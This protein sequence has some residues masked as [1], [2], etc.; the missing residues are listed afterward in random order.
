LA[1]ECL[2]GEQLP[3]RLGDGSTSWEDV[4]TDL[5]VPKPGFTGWIGIARRPI[6]PSL[7][8][9]VRSWGPATDNYATGIH[10]PLTL[11]AVSFATGRGDP[12]LLVAADIGWFKN[13]ED[14]AHVR[15]GVLDAVHADPTCVL[16]NLSHTHAGP[17]GTLLDGDEPARR[18]LDAVREAAANAARDAVA[19]AAP[20]TLACTVGRCDLAANRDLTA[21][22]RV[23]VGFNPNPR[24]DDTVLVGRIA[25][26][27]GAVLAVLVNYACH[28]TTLAWQNRL[29]SPDYVG[30]AREVVETAVPGALC[31]FLQGAAGELA[32]RHQ[33]VGDTEVA[34]RHGRSLGHAVMSALEGMPP[35]GSALIYRGV[36]ES[37]AALGMWEPAAYE[38]ASELDALTIEVELPLRRMPTIEEL[39]QTWAGINPVSLDER[40]RRARRV[41]AHYVNRDPYPFRVWIWRIGDC[42]VVGIPGEPYSWLQEEL[43]ARHPGR[44]LF[45]LGVTN[46]EMSAY[47]PV[48]SAY[49]P[50]RYQSWQ[51]P[52]AR[53]CLERVLEAA[54]AAVARLAGGEARAHTTRWRRSRPTR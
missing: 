30:A 3:A 4:V 43:R 28:P 8:V 46:A 9:P 39:E 40:L 36:V 53:G 20:A 35:P 10:R 24:A 31:V 49:D 47:L 50:D 52:Y 14:E 45:V 16:V 2:I 54:D 11:T 44:A 21:G 13:P 12:L 27:D 25:Q 19:T 41:R 33:Y 26:A 29:V 32:P 22:D 15:E 6:T 23:V 5:I 1:L 7:A 18:Y 42:I 37:G 51:T 34:D 38:P 48:E 17:S